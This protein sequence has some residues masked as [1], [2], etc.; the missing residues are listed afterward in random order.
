[1]KVGSELALVATE[2]SAM[3]SFGRSNVSIFSMKKYC[4]LLADF[5][6]NIENIKFKKIMNTLRQSSPKDRLLYG[7][8]TRGSLGRNLQSMTYF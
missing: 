1:L 3:G 8:F 5:Q 2:Q 4:K 7:M 6:T